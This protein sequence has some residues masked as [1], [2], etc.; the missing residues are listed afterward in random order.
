MK[1]FWQQFR[2]I[3]FTRRLTKD[4][5]FI[6]IGATLQALVLR[7]FL[8]PASLASGGV[9]GLSQIIN[10]YTGWPIGMMVL[11]GNLPLF[12]LGWRYLGGPRFVVRT[13]F[14]VLV[15]SVITD[16][17]V[18]YLSA[19]GI[20]DDLMLN[21][22][23]G[24]VLTGIGAG[25]VYRGQGTSGGSDI[26]GRILSHKRGIP[27]SQSYLITDALIVLL[28]GLAFSWEHALYAVVMLYVSGLTAESTLAGSRVVR[29]AMIVTTKPQLVG[30][31][32]L[33]G[34]QRGLTRL[35]ATGAFTGEERAVL[36]CVITRAEVE[37]LKALV[38]E[39][40]PQAFMVIGH[41]QE[42]MGEGFQS[43]EV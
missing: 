25:L 11:I 40:D 42:A 14:S 31:Q 15:F 19:S 39:A 17:S 4:M 10:H 41:A 6:F 33:T 34:L 8:V 38:S 37:R 23:Y 2:Q 12:V 27:V 29:T 9:S 36:Y 22:L 16:V 7:T 30:E 32:I 18:G 13:A 20:T 3:K 28:A 5:G 26:L 43:L 35:A 1:S 24:G 21:A